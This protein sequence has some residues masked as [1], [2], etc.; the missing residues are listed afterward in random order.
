MQKM[1]KSHLVKCTIV[2]I[3]RGFPQVGGR[4]QVEL[5]QAWMGKHPLAD[6]SC[7][8]NKPGR[9]LKT[10]KKCSSYRKEARHFFLPLFVAL[11]IHFEI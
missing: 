8:E 3:F 7:Y 10:W 11:I 5:F 9:V 6:F 4:L 1:R 2:F